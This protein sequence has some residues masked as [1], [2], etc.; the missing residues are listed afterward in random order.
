MEFVNTP[1]Q[2]MTGKERLA[3]G[4]RG[5]IPGMYIPENTEIS[6][7][8]ENYEEDP[9]TGFLNPRPG[10]AGVNHFTAQK[11]IKFLELAEQHWPNMH[12]VCKDMKVHFTTYKNH[13]LMD[14]KF[15]E[16]LNLIKQEK[17]DTVEGNVFTFSQRPA[18][19]MDRM[20]ILRAYRGDLYNPVQKVQHVGT[21]LSKDQVLARRA[22]LATVVD[23]EVV[24]A[25]SEILEVEA[26][27]PTTSVPESVQVPV[28]TPSGEPAGTRTSSAGESIENKMQLRDPLLTLMED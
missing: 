5:K 15:A 6:I 14:A 16:C 4:I 9:E 17:V 27:T 10:L 8:P 22:S 13:M 12:K 28:Q 21:E 25:S 20:A 23:A 2:T 1:I 18:N 19:F 3:P 26:S 11:K 24:K 7:N